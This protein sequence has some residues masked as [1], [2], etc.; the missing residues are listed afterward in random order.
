MS[1]KIII[2]GAGIA[3]LSAGCYGQMNGYKTTIYEVGEQPGGL[4]AA[5]KRKGYTFD[6]C[7]HWLMGTSP[8]SP[9]YKM[10]QE[11]GVT[12]NRRMISHDEFVRISDES[13][14]TFVVY[15]N[16]DKLEQHLLELSPADAPLIRDF[17]NLLRR[18]SKIDLAS[19][20]PA[21]LMNAADK[22]RN[23]LKM[24]PHMPAIM[25]WMKTPVS[26]Y[27]ARFSDPFLRRALPMIF[28]G[29]IP[30]MIFLMFL[31]P[32]DHGDCGTVEGGSWGF[33]HAIEKRYT[34]LGGEVHY[35][36]RVDEILVE[37]CQVSGKRRHQAVGVRLADG[38]VA[39]ADYVIS[40]ADGRT[41]VFKLLGG[42]FVDE[43]IQHAYDR[44]PTFT[45]ITQVS[46]G[47]NWDLS[48]TPHNQTQMLSR[49]V[50][51]NGVST[52]AIT[53]KHYCYDRSLAPLGKSVVESFLQA[54]Y[55]YWKKM[56][57]VDRE[58]YEAE[59]QIVATRV[60]EQM[61]ARYPGITGAIETV[62][63]ATPL[64]TERYTGNYKGSIQGWGINQET[65]TKGMKRTLP[66]LEDFYMAGQWVTVGGGLPGVA[67][68]GREVIQI[69]CHRD[70]KKFTTSVPG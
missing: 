20:K 16:T 11:L 57:E 21:E 56:A 66:G 53:L 37:P 31:A 39:H 14:R 54:D 68:S 28:G 70:G 41:T 17:A 48:D 67:P 4:C 59:K 45:A 44:W 52:D 49:P 58:R 61:E 42:N 30:M 10:W 29:D 55:D 6:G 47:V 2:I 26:E 51:L 50:E 63:V 35:K 43:D 64:T 40:A 69:I 19:D 34:E 25:K 38:T 33:S 46:I 22:V 62:D 7:I 9:Y 15:T 3:G 8:R 36:S 32:M 65:T 13:G 23:G 12:V 1:Q 60:I 5:W 18:W 27:A 24:A